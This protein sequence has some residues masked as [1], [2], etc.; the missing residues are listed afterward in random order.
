MQP[1]LIYFERFGEL[2]IRPNKNL[3][4]FLLDI[5]QNVLILGN[6]ARAT[7]KLSVIYK[8]TGG[9]AP[10]LSSDL[11]GGDIRLVIFHVFRVHFH[12]TLPHLLLIPRNILTWSSFFK[13]SLDQF[14][15]MPCF[16]L[17]KRQWSCDLP[18]LKGRKRKSC[19]VS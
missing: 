9:F 8:W 13:L 1:P 2:N 19:Q 11:H 5:F 16:R 18:C 4:H 3:F 14:N 6:N 7:I 12:R 15:A 17:I 10:S